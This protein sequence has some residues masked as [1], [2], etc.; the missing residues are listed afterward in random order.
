MGYKLAAGLV[1]AVTLGP[2]AMATLSQGYPAAAAFPDGSLVVLNT[3]SGSVELANLNNVDQLFGVVVPTVAASGSA[4]AGEVQ[5]ASTGVAN[6]LVTNVGGAVHI[7]D[8]LSASPIAGVA[9]VAATQNVRVIGTAQ[10]NFSGSGSGVTTQAVKDASGHTRQ[11]AIGEIPVAINTTQYAPSAG[12][13][14]PYAVPNWLQ[15]AANATA[16]KSVSPLKVIV[17][18]LVLALALLCITVLLYSSIRNSLISIGRNPLSKSSILRGLAQVVGIA[19]A[20]LIASAIAV[21]VILEL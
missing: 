8:Y 6:V 12:G 21:F 20:I 18:V 17:A 9:Q 16:G 14:A 3:Q 7:G 15:S 1:L 2:A 19:V 11:A 10:A 5:V 4:P 13:R